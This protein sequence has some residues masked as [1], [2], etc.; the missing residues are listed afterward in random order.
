MVGKEFLSIEQAE[1]F[2]FLYA[3][4][5]GFSVRKKLKRKNKSG[6]VNCRSWLCSSEGFR[7]EKYKHIENRKKEERDVTRVGCRATLKILLNKKTNTWFVKCFR[8]HHTHALAKSHE[9][10]FVRSNRK[11]TEPVREVALLM[12][13]AGIIT[14]H[15]WQYLVEIYGGWEKVGCIKADLY[16]GLRNNFRNWD[17]C[18][19]TTAMGYLQSKKGP[20]ADFFYNHDVDEENR[21]TNLFWA[22]GSMKVDYELFGDCLCFDATYKTNRYGKPLVILLGYNNHNRTCVFG[23]CLLQNEKWENYKWLLKTFLE[24]MEGKMPKT[25]LTDGCLSMKK[26]LNKVMPETVHRICSW[27]LLK[28]AIFHIHK[29]G[30]TKEFKK[31]IFRYYSNSEWEDNWKKLKDAYNLSNNIWFNEQYAMR[32]KWADTFLRGHFFGG[33]GQLEYASL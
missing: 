10:P 20:D 15:I 3:K 23:F 29:T 11:L 26:A 12:K 14:S 30:F 5:I 21:L 31:L 13:R 7:D 27:H 25:V 9:K 2:Y 33:P 1:K 18:D 8:V 4:L 22:D 16:R 17:D 24:C 28:N 19:T 32:H 6:V